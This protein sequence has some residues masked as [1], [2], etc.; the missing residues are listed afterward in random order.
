MT[1]KTALAHH[2]AKNGGPDR[3]AAE[4]YALAQYDE[5]ALAEVVRINLGGDKSITEFDLVRARIPSDG[6]IC[7]NGRWYSHRD[8]EW[9]GALVIFVRDGCVV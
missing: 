9:D 3:A 5:A 4:N 1:R 6:G 7:T 8:M 2:G